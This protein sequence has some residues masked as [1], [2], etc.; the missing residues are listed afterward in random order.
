[1]A[2]ECGLAKI[3]HRRNSCLMK[4]LLH[5]V[6]RES[7]PSDLCILLFRGRNLASFLRGV[8]DFCLMKK[9]N[10]KAMS[11]MFPLFV[12]EGLS[13]EVYALKQKA[14]TWDELE[15]SLRLRFSE[16]GMEGQCGECS[17]KPVVGAPSQAELSGLQRQVGVLEGRLARLEEAR[18]GKRKVSKDSP[19]KPAGQS[20]KWIEEDD[21][22][23]PLSIAAPKRRVGAQARN[24]GEGFVEIKE[25]PDANVTLAVMAPI[26]KRGLINGEASSA[27][28]HERQ[29]NGW[30]PEHWVKGVCDCWGKTGR[31]PQGNK[32]K[33]VTGE[34]G[35][36][37]PPKLTKA[38]RKARNLA[39]G[40][41]ATEKGQSSRQVAITPRELGG[42]VRPMGPPPIEQ[43]LRGQW[44]LCNQMGLWS[45]YNPYMPWA[46]G[47]YMGPLMNIMPRVPPP[48]QIQPV[49]PLWSPMQQ[50][51]QDGMAGRRGQRPAVG[52]GRGHGGGGNT[53]RGDGGRG[54]TGRGDGGRGNTGRGDGGRG[55]GG[56]GNDRQ[57]VEGRDGSR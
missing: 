16:D 34:K 53:G 2:E 29:K 22:E 7:M 50:V 44:A 56:R 27:A 19:S 41:Q 15:S 43:A 36:L 31:T 38:Q 52:R 48:V 37:E 1:M 20:G 45:A 39:Q 40:G 4:V 5:E 35:K 42:E 3:L 25:E 55:N 26:P 18:K 57:G 13:E 46:Q 51:P 6:L 9:W 24:K 21:R 47:N 17:V 12:C 33:G 14:K 10:K 54:N 49:G 32:E 11:Y 8:H 28:G 23:S 30:W